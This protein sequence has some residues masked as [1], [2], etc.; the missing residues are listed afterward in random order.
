MLIR[1]LR[2]TVAEVL[3]ADY[4][5]EA[6]N[7]PQVPF[8]N[9]LCIWDFVPEETIFPS[10]FA[11]TEWRRHLFLIERKHLGALRARM[12][13]SNLNVLLK[14]VT[15][16]ALRAF[17]GG[18]GLDRSEASEDSADHA[19]VL[20][21]ERDE[22]LQVLMQANLKLQEFNQEI[23]NFLARSIHDCRA[24]LTAISGYC[25]LLL[26]EAL[27]ALTADQREVLGRMQHSVRRLTR[28]TDSMLQLGVA[29]NAGKRMDIKR[30]NIR[31]CIDQALQI[32]SPVL[33]NKQISVALDVEPSPDGLMFEK[34]QIE[35]TLVNLIENACKFTPRGGSIEIRGYP[36]FWERRSDRLEPLPF[37]VDRRVKRVTAGNTFRI[38]IRDSGPGIPAV[39]ADKIFEEY[40]SYS[41]GQDR[42]GAGLG[43]AIC[44]MILSQHGGR[45]WA[46]SSAEG[47]VF[48]FVLPV[49]QNGSLAGTEKSFNKDASVA[50]C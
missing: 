44:R 36:Y 24:P 28:A 31:D 33:E 41:G 15:Q 37:S 30:G 4:G 22:M 39:R 6:G 43:L 9:D 47:G 12:G 26:E 7:P 13:A 25:E 1:L 21:S 18:Y 29:Q 5:V 27:G 3:G 50:V 16:I 45:V 48:S 2:E 10:G 17:L 20:R 34:S 49:Q 35:Q 8:R 46:E 40:S 32:L 42:S 19:D 23:S 38:D 14:P 11:H